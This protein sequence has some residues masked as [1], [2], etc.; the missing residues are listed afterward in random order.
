MK[1][2]IPLPLNDCVPQLAIV[3][4]ARLC[5]LDIQAQMI[6]APGGAAFHRGPEGFRG[7]KQEADL[8]Q[9][10]YAGID[11]SKAR[12]LV[13]LRGLTLAEPADWSIEDPLPPLPRLPDFFLVFGVQKVVTRSAVSA[14]TPP[15]TSQGKPSWR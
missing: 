1:F 9:P 13:A 5:G 8:K 7:F 11:A 3:G 10:F 15:R 6:D 2:P 12:G 4:N 14:P